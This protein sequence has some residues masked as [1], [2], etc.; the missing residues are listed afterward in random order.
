VNRENSKFSSNHPTT[1]TTDQFNHEFTSGR[2]SPFTTDEGM[3]ATWCPIPKTTRRQP[4]LTVAE[5]WK[6]GVTCT[7]SVLNDTDYTF[8]SA[9]LQ[10]ESCCLKHALPRIM[11]GDSEYSKSIRYGEQY[12][13]YEFILSFVYLVA[14]VSHIEQS[15]AKHRSSSKAQ[16]PFLQVTTYE[17]QRVLS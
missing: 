12:V 6:F 14:H 17:T 5:A 10:C 2:N 8:V 11:I 3:L 1:T 7:Q 16:L 13:P 9:N 4:S 15:S